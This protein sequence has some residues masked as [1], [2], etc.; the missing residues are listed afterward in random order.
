MEHTAQVCVLVC[1]GGKWCWW[2]GWG[3]SCCDVG[4]KCSLRYGTQ[5]LNTHLQ[6]WQPGGRQQVWCHGTNNVP[7][8]HAKDVLHMV[9]A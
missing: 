8:W 2:T 9:P 6:V 3:A 1:T 4:G 5:G 7:G